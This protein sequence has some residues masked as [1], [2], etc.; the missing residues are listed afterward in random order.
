MAK[1]SSHL[2][3]FIN[4]PTPCN[5]DLLLDFQSC[6][7]IHVFLHCIGGLLVSMLKHSIKEQE[8]R[9]VGSDSGERVRVERHVNQWT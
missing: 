1:F 5:I 4:D 7:S 9:L 3:D 2:R 6:I 8:Q